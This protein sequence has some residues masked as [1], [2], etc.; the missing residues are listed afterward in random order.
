MVPFS[1][2]F[3]VLKFEVFFLSLFGFM[4]IKFVQLG[5]NVRK[6][7]TM[8]TKV[9]QV[10]RICLLTQNIQVVRWKS[11]VSMIIYNGIRNNKSKTT[12]NR[13]SRFHYYINGRPKKLPSSPNHN[14]IDPKCNKNALYTFVFFFYRNK[15]TGWKVVCRRR[16]NNTKRSKTKI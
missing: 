5:K 16:K 15:I 8:F 11:R 2:T 3:Y 4:R 9:P 14:Y 6:L 1:K 13:F 12:K 7:N 10:Y